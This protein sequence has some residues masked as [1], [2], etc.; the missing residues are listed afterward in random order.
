MIGID[1]IK[2]KYEKNIIDKLDK[3]NARK[4]FNFLMEKKCD[5]LE[6]IASDYFDLFVFDYEYFVN[7]FEYLNKK[8][9]GEF[10]KKASMDMN[11]LEEFYN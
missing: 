3:E 9:N 2:E 6:D 11:L 4:I 1:E 10:L 8:Y 5:F 7:K